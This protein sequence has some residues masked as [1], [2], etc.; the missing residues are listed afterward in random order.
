MERAE[1]RMN[2]VEEAARNLSIPFGQQR[3]L[4]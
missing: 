4:R 3:Q 1:E 2:G